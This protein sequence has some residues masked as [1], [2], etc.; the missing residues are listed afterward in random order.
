MGKGGQRGAKVGKAP[1]RLTGLGSD[2]GFAI[3]PSQPSSSGRF[4]VLINQS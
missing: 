4:M 1:A 2:S 3:S